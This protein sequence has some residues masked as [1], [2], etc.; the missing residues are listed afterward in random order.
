[1]GRRPAKW[2]TLGRARAAT[3]DLAPLASEA[4]RDPGAGRTGF[5]VSPLSLPGTLRQGRSTEGRPCTGT[6]TA[7]GEAATSHGKASKTFIPLFLLQ[8]HSGARKTP[9][10]AC[11]CLVTMQ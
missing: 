11:L 3:P 5:C 4:T 6:G 7:Q 9:P 10:L 2:C 1:M 8:T